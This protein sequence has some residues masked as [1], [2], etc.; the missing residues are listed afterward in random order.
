MAE[1]YLQQ[2]HREKALEVFRAV[3]SQRPD[4]AV[5]R[6]RI[7]SLEATVRA[8]VSRVH[9]GPTIR[10]VLSRIALR[11]PGQ[12]PA[13]QQTNGSAPALDEGGLTG[14]FSNAQPSD[15]DEAAAMTLA[16][17]FMESNGNGGED[18][19]VGAVA[20]EPARPAAG[21][22]SLDSVFGE[23]PPSPAASSSE[24]ALNQYFSERA[25]GEHNTTP[26][27]VE[28]DARDESPEEVA[29]F[30]QWLEGLKKR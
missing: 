10:D 8:A 14:L 23:A 15:A 24:F 9:T 7:E 29:K 13:P 27:H 22:L 12:R 11:R 5:L 30:T 25:T 21:E 26:P 19:A 20:G 16:A 1:L 6:A 17:A 2:G 4:D 3:L 28:R 18:Q